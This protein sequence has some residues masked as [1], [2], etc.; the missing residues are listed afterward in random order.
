MKRLDERTVGDRGEQVT[1]HLALLGIRHRASLRLFPGASPAGIVIAGC[2]PAFSL[3]ERMLEGL[4]PRSLFAISA[5]TD[6]ALPALQRGRVH[7]AVVHGLT[8]AL[9]TSHIPV[10]AGTS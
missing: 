1:R 10:S 4:G 9:P 6:S 7:A 2:D 3:A 8:E 5:P